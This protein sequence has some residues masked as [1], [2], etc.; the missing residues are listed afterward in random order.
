[1]KRKIMS[2]AAAIAAAALVLS[3]CGGDSDDSGT[4]NGNGDAS[5]G[6]DAAPVTIT[7][8][9]WSLATTPEF[10]TLV[11]AFEAENED[12]TVEIV[13]YADG[14]DY[15]TQ[16]ITDLAGGTAPDVYPLKNL[17]HFFTYQDGGQLVDVSDVA[18]ELGEEVSGVDAYVI[19]GATYAVP[20]RQ[21]AWFIY[22]NMDLFEAAGVD[23]PD[24]SWTWDDYA[25]AAEAL[26]EGLAGTETPA[27]GAYQHS[28]QSTLQGFATAQSP[29]A[30]F[31]S[32]DWEYFV[33]YYE[34]VLEMQDNGS[35]VSYST[36]TTNSLSY[37]AQFGTQQAA[38]TVMGS[39][40]IAT[41]LAEQDSGDADDFAWGIA[42]APQYDSST[43]DQPVTFGD[44]TGLG[45]NSA[46]EGDE[47]EAAKRFVA[48]AA[49]EQAGEALAGIGITPAASTE[50]VTE[51]F[52]NLEG[53]PMDDLSQFAF[54]T[55]D[56]RP[57]NTVDANNAALQNILGDAHSSIMSGS[58]SPQDGIDEA[59]RRASDEVN[60]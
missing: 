52:F 48:F 34:R 4:T 19:D 5:G 6:D 11:E 44:P 25:D 58:E 20:Y 31:L 2:T 37:Q 36:V 24:G 16:M 51:A 35:L 17:N 49:G 60:N 41:L 40:Y 9:G 32:G 46:V 54:S 53:M 27:T 28:W 1:M 30:D 59:M 42:P 56:V 15:D 3:A 55:H 39:W 23:Q 57:E 43:T 8:A 21:D 7:F 12:I 10:E 22:Y 26:T 47:L 18:A 50:A 13:E 33:P 38:M 14:D 29:G 45:I